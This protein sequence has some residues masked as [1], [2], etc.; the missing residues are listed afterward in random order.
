MKQIRIPMDELNGL[1][2]QKVSLSA[3]FSKL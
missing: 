2:A 1:V 3:Q